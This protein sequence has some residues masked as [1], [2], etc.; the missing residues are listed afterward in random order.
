MSRV[1]TDETKHFAQ[2][3]GANIKFLRLN[4]P[5][6]MP[7]KVPAAHLGITYQQL[8]KYENGKNL[9]CAFRIKQ[10]ADFYK[11]TPND[12]LNPSYIHENTKNYEVLDRGFDAEEVSHGD[13]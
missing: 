4:Q 8:E 2:M 11:V 9:P 1:K 5:Q 12:I 3:L 10:L 13:I 6:F 7:Q